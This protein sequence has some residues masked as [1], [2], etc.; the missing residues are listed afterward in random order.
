MIPLVLLD[1]D[2]TVV[3]ASGD[4]K[5]CVWEAVDKALQAGMILAACTGRPCSGVAQKVAARLGPKNPH[6]F[7]S[8]AII[9]YPSGETHKAFALRE[10]NTRRLVEAARDSGLALELY[11]PSAVYVERKTPLSE[12][13]AKMLGVTAII[14][15]FTDVLENEPV[16]RAQWVVS[17]E[18]VDQAL[19]LELD[20]IEASGAVSP[21]LP[22]VNFVSLTQR[23]VS[24]GS[25]AKQ[26][27]RFLEID[28]QR[29]MAI[30]DS[31]GDLSMLEAVG[32]PRVMG[33]A[34]QALRQRFTTLPEVE[35][36]GVAEAIH[37]AL[38]H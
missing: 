28:P 7:H 9:S 3:G 22:G 29:V 25:A 32:H 19:R 27:C 4:V 6:I 8:G 10:A 23:G 34:S 21:A 2:G 11:T 15:N 36:C 14:R 35:A 12:A 31:S 16:V 30:G 26:L 20:G 17:D 5:P 38:E 33:N 18:Q 13:H 1:L 37:F 24:K